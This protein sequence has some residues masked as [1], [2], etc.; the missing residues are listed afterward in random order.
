MFSDQSE[1]EPMETEE[2]KTEEGAGDKSLEGE[3]SPSGSEDSKRVKPATESDDG[4][5][6]VNI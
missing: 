4:K 1:S 5:P 6:L 2:E 3:A